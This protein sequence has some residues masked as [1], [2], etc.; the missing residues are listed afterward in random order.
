MRKNIIVK[1]H[2]STDCGAAALAMICLYYGKEVTITG[3]RDACGTDILGT[4][5]EGLCTGAKKLGLDTKPIRISDDEFIKG[6]FTLPAICHVVT[7]SGFHHYVV[8]TKISAEGVVVLDPALGKRK[9]SHEE[10][11]K[12][13]D[14]IVILIKPSSDFK[15]SKVDKKSLF[16][17]LMSLVLNQKWLFI[18]TII[19]GFLI[20]V[21]GIVSSF[22]NKFLIDEILPFGLK[23][24]L[25]TLV[26]IFI[27]VAL[28]NIALGAIRQHVVLHLSQK[29][30]IPLMLGYYTHVLNLPMKFFGTRKTG[31]IIT[32]F[33]DAGTV[34]SVVS[35]IILTLILDVLFAI[36][37]GVVLYMINPSLFG[38]IVVFTLVS[39]VLV[40]I[41]R[42]PYKKINREQMEAAASLNSTTIESL[43]GI[44]T[45]KGNAA[46]E[47]TMEKIENRFVRTLRI[48]YRANV[49]SNYQ[50]IV[51]SSI[52]MIGG[53][54]IMWL[55]AM[56]VISGDITLGTLMAFSSLTGFFMGPIGRLVNVQFQIQ[57]ADIAL[58][59]LSEILDVEEEC[60]THKGKSIPET[61]FGN[62]SIEN[63]SFRYGFR[64]P[65]LSDVSIEIKGGEKVALVGESGCGKTTICKVIM[66]LWVPESGKVNIAGYDL[67]ELDIQSYRKRVAYVRQE[68]E[69][70][71]GTITDNIRVSLPTA[72]DD[73]IRR[74]CEMAGC[75]DFI[76]RLP[77]RYETYLEEA[78]ANL[79][80]GERQRIGLARAFVKKPELLILDE[81]TSNLDFLSEAK[82]YDTLFNKLKCTT[83]IVAHRLSTIRRC[84]KIFMMANG[85]VAEAGTHDELIEKHGLYWKMWNSQIGNDVSSTKEDKLKNQSKEDAM[86][87]N[88]DDFISYV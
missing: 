16:Y 83:I 49:L 30:S 74:A 36:V 44:E 12:E 21:L 51:S 13:F 35:G 3:L 7:K 78:G 71:S 47:E 59:R 77:S 67:E 15:A 54:L 45:V 25:L 18:T 43:R 62:I 20:T 42:Q 58:R 76:S 86:Y 10:F 4:N 33:Q 64:K 38:V 27:I 50:G 19:A 9:L 69:L 84:D 31:D 41:F 32:R 53:L 37:T 57:E 24:Q 72:T 87:E 26:L 34:V 1:Q 55:G 2:D 68:V 11:S 6:E 17:R 5:V 66:G 85:K 63:L 23:D 82:V 75:S 65:I 39:V 29:I 88:D 56:Y 61:F 22:F 52:S 81:A 14:N 79:S 70:F 73:D 46:E 48:A 8:L 28:T 60:E 80:G 40:Y